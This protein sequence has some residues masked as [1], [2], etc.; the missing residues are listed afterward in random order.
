MEILLFQ[1]IFFCRCE[2]PG[3]AMAAADKS[4]IRHVTQEPLRWTQNKAGGSAGVFEC[5]WMN[6]PDKPRVL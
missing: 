2:I 4:E 1:C 5:V 3:E 6:R